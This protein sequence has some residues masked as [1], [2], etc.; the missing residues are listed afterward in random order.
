ML[1]KTILLTIL[2]IM[3]ALG[4]SLTAYA[5]TTIDQ[6]DLSKGI[7]HVTFSSDTTAKI[8]LMVEKDTKRYTYDLNSKGITESFSLQM[9]SGIYKVSLLQ[10][11]TGK[12]YKL[13]SSEKITATITE[14]NSVYLGSIQNVNWNVDSAA[15]KKAVALTSSTTNLGKK[16]QIL[17]DY[18]AKNNKYDYT[19]FAKLPSTYL[20]VIDATLKDKSGICY[21]FASLYAAML[22]SQGIPAKLV[23]G[24]APN[25]AQGYHAWNEAYDSVNKK[26]IVID[27][28]YDLQ[29]IKTKPKA[30]SMIK[31]S[32]DYQKIYEY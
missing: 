31:K 28:T 21:D 27:S 3:L 30:V 14:T 6:T 11:T 4:C 5:A 9:G 26:W 16:A 32:S 15:V 29:M 7:I 19:K 17:W 25:Y 20:P 12:S 23:K 2:M 18:M 10:N 22:R 8:K 13:L 1:R 24:Y